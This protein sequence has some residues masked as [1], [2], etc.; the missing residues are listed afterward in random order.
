MYL[1]D[2]CVFVYIQLITIKCFLF[3]MLHILAVI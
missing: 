3:H 2:M 1:Y